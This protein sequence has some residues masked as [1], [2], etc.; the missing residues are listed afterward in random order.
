MPLED[1][2]QRVCHAF[3]SA[4]EIAR[5]IRGTFRSEDVPLSHPVR[6]G[7]QELGRTGWS[8][9]GKDLSI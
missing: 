4:R 3:F 7:G 5:G 9:N 6:E 1:A 2:I 8:K